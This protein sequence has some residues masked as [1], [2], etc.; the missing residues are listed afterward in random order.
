[1]G[2]TSETRWETEGPDGQLDALLARAVS[3][4]PVL[5]GAE[6]VAR[7]AGVRPRAS[8]RAP[9][10]GPWP[11]RPGHFVANGGVKIGFGMAPKLAEVMADLLLEGCDRVPDA[12]RVEALR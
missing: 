2:S 10:M 1:V 8:S 5:R 7:W 6:L 3:A 11:G 4:L 9:V 12:F